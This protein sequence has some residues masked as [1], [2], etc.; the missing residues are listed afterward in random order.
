MKK[1][2]NKMTSLAA[3]TENSEKLRYSDL[4]LIV[5]NRSV[6]QGITFKEM[7]IELDFISRL[8]KSESDIELSDEELIRVQE[9]L[10]QHKWPVLH[11]DIVEFA[12][13]F[14]NLTVSK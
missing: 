4:L 9:V 5:M 6:P 10:N 13:S 7:K 12:E 8:Q 1:L 11:S 14:C 2:E 3:S